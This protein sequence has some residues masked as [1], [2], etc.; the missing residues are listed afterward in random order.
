[1]RILVVEDDDRLARTVEVGLAAAGYVV[2]IERDG[3]AAWFRGDTEAFDAIV[4]DLGL[5]SMDG[6]TALKRWRNAGRSCPV[7]I[8]TARGQ[9]EERVEGI[10]A[11]AD[12][13]L[14]KPFRLEEVV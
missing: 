1:M 3:E 2:E 9:W 14:V 5:P 6:L 7:L 8:L 11:G 4:L 10:E 13:Y 12:D